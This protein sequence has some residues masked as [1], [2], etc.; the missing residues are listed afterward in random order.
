MHNRPYTEEEMAA[1][2]EKWATIDRHL[3]EKY[4][5]ERTRYQPIRYLGCACMTRDK[6]LF[7][8]DIDLEVQA[9]HL[10][11]IEKSANEA[12]K[13]FADLREHP[14][15]AALSPEV[16]AYMESLD[17]I[18]KGVENARNHLGRVIQLSVPAPN[19][20]AQNLAEETAP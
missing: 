7:V 3:E 2:K 12:K 10:A 17:S 1:I 6:G 20:N 9:Q 16:N 11:N 5:A 14:F 18:L 19:E 13:I 15:V 8:I 4:S